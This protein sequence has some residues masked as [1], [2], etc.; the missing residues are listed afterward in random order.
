MLLWSYHGNAQDYVIIY[1]T[2][3]TRDP[4]DHVL[5]FKL[6]AMCNYILF[7]KDKSLYFYF[8]LPLSDKLARGLFSIRG[9]DLEVIKVTYTVQ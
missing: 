7:Q 6:L 1:H 2:G 8:I 4:T 9:R 5:P 3:I